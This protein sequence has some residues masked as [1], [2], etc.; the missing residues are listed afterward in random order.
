MHQHVTFNPFVVVDVKDGRVVGATV[1]WSDSF[2]NVT[3]QESGEL[4]DGGAGEDTVGGQLAMT[5][6]DRTDVREAVEAAMT[7][8]LESRPPLPPCYPHCD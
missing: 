3:D 6:L 7:S 1:D 4:L 8:L 2:L 5:F